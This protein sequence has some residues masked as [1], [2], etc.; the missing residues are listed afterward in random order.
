MWIAY[1]TALE[2]LVAQWAEGNYGRARPAFALPWCAM[3]QTVTWSE[4]AGERKQ[5]ELI[6]MT[7]EAEVA[8]TNN[9][10]NSQILAASVTSAP[11]SDET[12]LP[13][14]PSDHRASDRE[15]TDGTFEME[16]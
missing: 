3:M 2:R 15:G 7:A 13:A 10:L 14:L 4:Q 1:T 5:A 16:Q 8:F 9:F 12:S 11:P 6:G